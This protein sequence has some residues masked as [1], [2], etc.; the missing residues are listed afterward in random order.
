MSMVF[1]MPSV[2]FS[3]FIFP[4][5]NHAVDFPGAGFCV[6]PLTYF[7]ELMRAIILRGA[8]WLS[9]GFHLPSLAGMGLALFCL[10]AAALFKQKD[11]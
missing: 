4:A 9:S 11:A 2:F 10:C 5:G 6:C 1:I 8:A 7:I 3:G